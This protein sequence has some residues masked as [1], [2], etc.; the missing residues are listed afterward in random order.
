MNNFSLL[1]YQKEDIL[2][3]CDIW[4]DRSVYFGHEM[5]LGKCAMAIACWEKLNAK[6]ILVVCPASVRPVW[7]S[8]TEKWLTDSLPMIQVVIEQSAHLRNNFSRVNCIIISYDLTVGRNLAEQLLARHWDIFDECH[9]LGN[10]TSKRT[11]MC[12]GSLYPKAQKCL[13]LS[14]SIQRDKII[15]VWPVFRTLCPAKIPPYWQF[16]NKYVY[17]KRTNYGIKFL[18]GKNLKELGKIAKEN[19]LIRRKKKD[20]LHE[21]PDKLEQKLVIT[22]PSDEQKRLESASLDFSEEAKMALAGSGAPNNENLAT[23]RRE[24]GESKINYIEDS[25]LD[26]LGLGVSEENCGKLVIFCYHHTVFRLIQNVLEKHQIKHTG[27]NGYS[28]PPHRE[29]AVRLFQDNEETKVFLGTF[30]AAE[31][32]TLHAASTVLFAEMSWQLSQNEQAQDRL[33]RI[34]QK[35]TV[36]VKYLLLENTLDI[37][38]YNTYKRK[39]GDKR[40]TFDNGKTTIVKHSSQSIAYQSSQKGNT[41]NGGAP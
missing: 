13:F 10:P 19:F 30:A 8:E 34:G 12:L 22:L 37:M 33:H 2:Q 7:R 28:L 25:I 11:K 5:G 21:L 40:R 18:G 36:Y 38:V 35:N 31:G 3:A 4:H 6:N 41:T 1:P 27:I 24:L 20:V 14:G 15:N 39:S 9:C 32:I 17:Y 29:A 23:L 16:V 26:L